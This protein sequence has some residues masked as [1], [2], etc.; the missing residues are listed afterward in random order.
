MC[1]LRMRLCQSLILSIML[2]VCSLSSAEITTDGTM[3]QARSLSG[4]AY[5]IPGDLG[6]QKGNNLFHS[7]SKFNVNTD[8]SATFTGRSGIE[9][10]IG[11]V[12][13]GNASWIDGLMACEIT[14]A[15]LW[16]LNPFGVLF[17][18]N[19]KLDITGS[20]YA[21]TADY[22]TLSGG[23]VF[24]TDPGKTSRLTTASPEAFGFL[25]T[26]PARIDVS[27]SYLKVPD[28]K[29]LSL[30]GGD[31][32]IRDGQIVAP[33]GHIILASLASPGVVTITPDDLSV[34]VSGEKGDISVS[35]PEDRYPPDVAA[36]DVSGSPNGR[37]DVN[38][39]SFTVKNARVEASNHSDTDSNG[40][41]FIVAGKKVSIDQGTIDVDV[42]GEGKGGNINIQTT[43]LSLVDGGEISCITFGGGVGGNIAITAEDV[44]VDGTVELGDGYH[45]PGMITCQS[46]SAGDAGSLTME[47]DSLSLNNGGRIS[48]Q[49]YGEG[50]GG[51]I[52]IT[53]TAVS[54][55]GGIVSQDGNYT[56]SMITCQTESSGN[57]GGIEM[58]TDSLSVTNGGQIFGGTLGDGVGGNIKITAKDVKV[59]GT[60]ELGDGYHRPS[61]I[62]CQSE[63]A[64]DAGS[65][66]METDSL[67]ITNGGRIS[68]Q[69]YGEGA[70]GNIKITAIDVSVDGG[71][72]SQ[73]GN[74]TL[75]MITCQTESSGDAGNLEM[76]TDLLS[77]TNGGQIFGGT[78]GDGVGGNIKIT[79]KDVKIDGAVE[80]G[81]GY[82]SPSMITCQSES[83]GDAGSLE[84][85]TDLL[86]ITNGGRISAQSYGEGVGGN[87]KITAK[88]VKVDGSIESKD[89]NYTLSMITCQTES[90]GDA[91]SLEMAT[92]MLS[93]TNG[94]QIF[95]GTL[96]DGV[97]GNVKITAK[98]VK[99]DGAVELGDG[100]H[101]PSMITCQRPLL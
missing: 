84:M 56:L 54:V 40:G 30:T 39:G 36:V 97:G 76:K 87:I 50:V 60:V 26:S 65:L 7:F 51:N 20:F 11:R 46:E 90:S 52:K 1:P 59:D 21:S 3:G 75:S 101:S 41:I 80:L 82:H 25:S 57:A 78:L 8:E 73:D 31:I 96:G 12:T 66:T 86:T 29:T 9:N 77:V 68:A 47:T 94:G 10:V 48:A 98:D 62:T 81:D 99:I 74:F 95:G 4:P 33:G 22:L 6:V 28:G 24:Y 92:D 15:N 44:N 38:C 58:E 27:G 42:Y 79:A 55:D 45:R 100:Y 14:G 19:A 61:M 17:G 13:G 83:S 67:S 88:D 2:L 53:A 49:T 91:G 32:Q 63:S 70:G 16:L 35:G 64:G 34:T 37:I 93:V 18:P 5:T 89:G 85:E 43:S 23:G 71:I 72:E 69:A